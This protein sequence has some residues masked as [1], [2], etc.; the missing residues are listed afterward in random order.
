MQPCDTNAPIVPGAF[1]EKK[2]AIALI[3]IN[4]AHQTMAPR[5]QHSI[6]CA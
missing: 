5:E 1:Y 6:I 3:G 4:H 2:I